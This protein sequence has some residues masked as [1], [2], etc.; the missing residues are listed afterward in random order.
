MTLPSTNE[1]IAG[2]RQR[3]TSLFGQDTSFAPSIDDPDVNVVDMDDGIERDDHR[4]QRQS[5]NESSS[6][7]D[8]RYSEQ[9]AARPFSNLGSSPTFQRRSMPRI[10]EQWSKVRQDTKRTSVHP[11]D[12]HLDSLRRINKLISYIPRR[13]SLNSIHRNVS[14]A[15]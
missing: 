4:S 14:C 1:P 11:F 13:R 2:K 7:A 8:Q 12:L 5:H 6:T 15:W 10:R 3:I 9:Q